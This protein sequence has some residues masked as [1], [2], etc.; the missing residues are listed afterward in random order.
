MSSSLWCLNNVVYWYIIAVLENKDRV[1]FFV[2]TIPFLVQ[3]CQAFPPLCEDATTLLGQV[4]RVCI[5]NLTA[6]SNVLNTEI[7]DLDE[8]PKKKK[9]VSLPNVSLTARYQRLYRTVQTTFSNIV[10]KAIVTRNIYSWY[11][12]KNISSL[13]AHHFVCNEINSAVST[14]FCFHITELDY[15]CS[16]SLMKFWLPDYPKSNMA[17]CTMATIL[18]SYHYWRTESSIY[19]G[20]KSK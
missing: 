8:P 2:Q 5:S 11:S 14:R 15:F 7:S 9:C 3:V 13:I 10:K 12:A 4:G 16:W 20:R 17:M 1:E 19:M 18:N 6:T